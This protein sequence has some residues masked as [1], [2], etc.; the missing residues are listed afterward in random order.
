[1]KQN[2]ARILTEIVY[3]TFPALFFIAATLSPR[4][5]DPG[6]THTHPQIM[7]TKNYWWFPKLHKFFSYPIITA[8]TTPT[9][10]SAISHPDLRYEVLIQGI[11][12]F[13]SLVKLLLTPQ[14]IPPPQLKVPITGCPHQASH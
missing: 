11:A 5:P 12:Q 10:W 7:A 14:I 9:D 13:I 8:H 2:L 1:M 4:N 6:H 3:S